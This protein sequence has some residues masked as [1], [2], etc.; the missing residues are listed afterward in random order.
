MRLSVVYLVRD[1]RGVV[2]SHMKNHGW[3]LQFAIRSWMRQ[4]LNIIR[5][6]DEFDHTV[7][8]H[9]EDLCD[10]TDQTLAEVH[11]L[12]G[13]S[14][15]PFQGSFTEGE[16]HILGNEMRLRDSTI[17][18]DL[19]WQTELSAEGRDMVR[20]AGLAFASRRKDHSLSRILRAYLE[21]V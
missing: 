15:H 4:Q 21:D 12:V 2:F 7:T 9:Y 20:E 16:H 17:S 19:R 8:I 3:D 14:P 11:R 1:P 18:K 6:K 10:A 13:L 5:I